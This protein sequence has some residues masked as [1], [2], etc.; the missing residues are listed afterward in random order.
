M[1][2]STGRL[3]LTLTVLGLVSAFILA[4]VF[5][6][7]LPYII[8]H[9]AKAQ[10]RAVFAVLPGASDYKEVEKDGQVFFE[11]FDQSGKRIGVAIKATGGGFQGMITVMVG[12][13]PEAEKVYG[14]Q[15]LEHQETPGLGAFIT[16]EKYEA[17]FID[18]PFGDYKVVKRPA[19][20]PYE[21]E[22]ISG[23]TISSTKVTSIVEKAIKDIQRAYGGGA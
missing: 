9:Q 6:W 14:I 20:S 12:T 13:D 1:N 5:Q 4:F 8:K 10:E 17:N 21:V 19:T 18:K 11:G 15:V 3:I 23:A 22:A 2:N 7:T 16:G